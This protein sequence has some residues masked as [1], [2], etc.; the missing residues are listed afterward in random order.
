MKR[1]IL[2]LSD[3]ESEMHLDSEGVLTYNRDQKIV[4]SHDGIKKGGRNISGLGKNPG[5]DG[6]FYG[7]YRGRWVPIDVEKKTFPT[8]PGPQE[9]LAGD[10]SAGFYG[11]VSSND[12]INGDEL[13][14]LVGISAG[15][16]H[17]HGEPWLKFS[18]DGKTLFIA[19]KTLRYNLN[20]R[21]IESAGAVYGNKTVQI[22]DFNYRIR[23][24]KGA[25]SD[26]TSHPSG[27]NSD[28]STTHG[29]EWNRL[30]YRVCEVDPPS[31]EGENWY[32]Y[33]ELELGLL[34]GTLGRATW[35]QETVVTTNYRLGRGGL[36]ISNGGTPSP[37]YLSTYYGWRPVLEL[38]G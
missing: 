4:L 34:E 21:H 1:R 25:N 29:S 22:G 23:L 5:A 9:L 30:M 38:I 7:L 15:T 16:P 24:I 19:K 3:Q 10:S 36:S 18:L 27:T 35:C 12:L 8:G 33:S 26:P 31:Q 6:R 2:S 17:N 11:E 32:T 28:H 13:S 20:W 37:N 14:L